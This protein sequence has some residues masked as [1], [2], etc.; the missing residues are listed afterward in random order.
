MTTHKEKMEEWASERLMESE[1]NRKN[2]PIQ[3]K[4]DRLPPRHNVRRSIDCQYL[5]IEDALMESGY[6]DNN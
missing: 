3:P 6:Y 5:S 2:G 4:P 1:R